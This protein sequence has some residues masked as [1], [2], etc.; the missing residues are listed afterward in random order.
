MSPIGKFRNASTELKLLHLF[1]THKI[2]GWRRH[3]DLPGRPDFAFRKQH[4]L[5]SLSTVWHRCPIC[6]WTP[7]SNTE[8]WVPKLERNVAKDHEANRSLKQK[9]WRVLPNLGARIETKTGGRS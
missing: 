6:N 9:G 2:Q 3:L 8:Y 1:R 4:T 7:A 5:P